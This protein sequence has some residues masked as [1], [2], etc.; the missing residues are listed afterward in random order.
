MRKKYGETDTQAAE[1]YIQEC[2]AAAGL[3][4]ALRRVLL[5][6]DGKIY[7]KRFETALQGEIGRIYAEKKTNGDRQ[8]LNVWY[9]SESGE[10]MTILWC[11][12]PGD[13][14]IKAADLIQAAANKRAE[15]LKNA[16]HM[17]QVLP[18]IETRRQQIE[19]LKNQLEGVLCD[20]TY[21]EKDLFGLHQKISRW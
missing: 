16:D 1:R 12:L 17:A 20:L 6:F 13:K 7:N 19:L 10:Y 15:Y 5:S 3:F 8:V 9:Y 18:T 4:P 11:D 14:R 21:T 2:R